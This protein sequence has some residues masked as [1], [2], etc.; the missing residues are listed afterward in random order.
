MKTINAQRF[1]KGFEFVILCLL[2]LSPFLPWFVSYSDGAWVSFCELF[3]ADAMDA[4]GNLT[5]NNMPFSTVLRGGHLQAALVE[6]LF[7]M[8]IWGYGLIRLGKM[9]FSHPTTWGIESVLLWVSVLCLGGFSIGITIYRDLGWGYW[10]NGGILIAT[11]GWWGW[12]FLTGKK[13]NALSLA[14]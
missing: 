4:I 2:L 14:R 7:L 5:Y 1:L 12:Q 13:R 3:A 9:T 11:A 10:L 6:L 8:C